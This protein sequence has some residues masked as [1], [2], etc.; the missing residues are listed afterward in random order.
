MEKLSLTVFV[1]TK[2]E[3]VNIEKCFA[4]VAEVAERVVVVD[5]GSTDRTAELARAKGAEVV[6]HP[7]TNQAAQMNWA[8]GHVPIKTEWVFRLDADEEFLP[9]LR[10]ELREVLPKAPPEAAGFFIKRRVYF[11]GRWMRHG[12]YYPV[13]FLR[14]WRNGKAR[15]ELRE[16]DEHMVLGAGEARYLRHDFVD[17]DLKGLESWIARQNNHSSREVLAR[18]RTGGN[19]AGEAMPARFA[20]T[21]AERR[22]WLKRNIFLAAP[23]FCRAFALYVYRYVFRLGF[24][25]GREGLIFHFMSG[26]WYPF[27]VDAK[28]HEASRKPLPR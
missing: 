6:E 5:S 19:S 26:L 7:F 18:L 22:R 21:P 16:V 10:E 15:C 14:L 20:G 12:A 2:N 8:L 4:S 9:E 23:H 17:R 24:L 25:D 3:E 13:W 1:L 27:L 11:M 28:L